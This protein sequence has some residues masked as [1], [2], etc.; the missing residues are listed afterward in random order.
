MSPR[1]KWVTFCKRTEYPKLGYLIYRLRCAGVR[2]RQTKHSFHAPI[3]EVPEEDEHIAN[4][5]LAEKTTLDG[6][7]SLRA[8][9]RL[10]DL[11]DDSPCFRRFADWKA[12]IT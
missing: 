5:I 3:L 9:H 7:H 1:T 10:D 6:R 4:S 2:T 11:A 8:K 12:N